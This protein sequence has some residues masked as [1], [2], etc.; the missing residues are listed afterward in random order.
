MKPGSVAS[1]IYVLAKIFG[2][3]VHY[4][5]WRVPFTHL[6][7][8]DHVDAYVADWICS[9]VSDDGKWQAAF[10]K[11]RLEWV[12]PISKLSAMTSQNT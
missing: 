3:S 9:R 7:Q 12:R 4:I 10:D 11:A 5:L 6:A 2:W 8:F 1:R